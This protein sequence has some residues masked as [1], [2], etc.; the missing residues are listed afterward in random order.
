MKKNFQRMKRTRSHWNKCVICGKPDAIVN[1]PKGSICV[2][3]SMPAAKRKEE[4]EH[5]RKLKKFLHM[6]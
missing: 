2:S 5:L 4:K 3:C 1:T 6:M